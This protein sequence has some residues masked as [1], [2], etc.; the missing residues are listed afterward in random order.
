MPRPAR[1]PL[2]PAGAWRYH[3]LRDAQGR[4][5]GVARLRDLP[6]RVE[7]PLGS[8][9]LSVLTRRPAHR[10]VVDL[11]V[12]LVAGAA[13]TR[14]HDFEDQ[15]VR[16]GADG[17]R[18]ARWKGWTGPGVSAPVWCDERGVE[19]WLGAALPEDEGAPWFDHLGGLAV[20]R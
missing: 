1:V 7:G 16:A 14:P 11:D 8:R 4:P 17:E 12:E 18:D 13:P 9:L 19:H 5:S 10:D 2:P 6:R 20:G 3:R 15:W